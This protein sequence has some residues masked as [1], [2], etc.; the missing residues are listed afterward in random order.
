MDKQ[1]MVKLTAEILMELPYEKTE[2]VCNMVCKLAVKL[3]I[4]DC[5]NVDTEKED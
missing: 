3:G 4:R 1:K 5:V 2:F